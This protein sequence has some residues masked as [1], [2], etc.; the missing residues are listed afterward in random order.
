MRISRLTKRI[1]LILGLALVALAFWQL[2]GQSRP[3]ATVRVLAASHDLPVGSTLSS[4][5]TT[6]LEVTVPSSAAYLTQ[7][8]GRGS[9]M[10]DSIPAGELIPLRAVGLH[11]FAARAVVTLKPAILPVRVLRVGDVVDVWVQRA[12]ASQLQAASALELVATEAEVVA[13]SAEQGGFSAAGQ[14]VDLSVARG[15]LE[16][17]VSASL[18]AQAQLELVRTPSLRD[19]DGEG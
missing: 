1:I 11:P 5:A 18:T 8:P 4:S 19:L 9:I 13:I 3:A 6:W 7:P 15:Q 16:G 17:L 14:R 2:S 10:L 12:N